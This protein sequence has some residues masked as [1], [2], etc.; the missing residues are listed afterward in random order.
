MKILTFDIEDWFHILDN[1]STKT[2][3]EW[4]NYET[5]I[6]AGVDR[7]LES[8]AERNIKATFFCLGWIAAKHPVVIK[9]ISAQGHEIGTHSHM[10]QLVY[11]MTPKQF[12]DDLKKSIHLLQDITG[13]PVNSYR[14]P[15]FS[16]TKNESWVFEILLENGIKYDCSIF[17]VHRAHGGMPEVGIYKPF[18]LNIN[19][20]ILKEFPM[21]VAGI[22]K[23]KIGYS[24]GGYFRL[25]P[26]PIIKSIMKRHDYVMTYFHPRDF[27]AA[28]PKLPGLSPLK[29]FKAYH[30][31]KTSFPKFQKLISEFDFV[32]LT[33]FDNAFDWKKAK[34]ISLP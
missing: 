18:L 28:Q 3:L 24:G 9:N 6:Y 32:S 2:E 14:A 17:P 30:G 33:E 20:G 1:D 25:L 5:R 22:G 29:K 13:K 11:E 8:L 16:I 15:G 10:H 7:I 4:S 19:G 12:E 23:R 31:L 27:D 21:S 26:F 34:S